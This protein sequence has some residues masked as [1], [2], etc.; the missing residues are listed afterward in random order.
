MDYYRAIE[1]INEINNYI[2]GLYVV[3][4]IRR[5]EEIINDIDFVTRRPMIDVIDDFSLYF[6]DKMQ[7]IK[8][9]KKYSK[10]KI[11]DPYF[12][13]GSIDIDIWATE[14]DTEYKFTK[15][16][17]SMDKGHVIGLSRKAEMLGMKLS[18]KGLYKGNEEIKVKT[19]IELKQML[20]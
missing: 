7:I 16:L 2:P 8:E 17:R 18:T 1:F 19:L 5:K 10:I 12:M 15:W 13:R 3:G 11:T 14:T 6:G 4:S 20:L 9:G